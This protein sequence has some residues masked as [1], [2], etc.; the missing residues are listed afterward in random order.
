MDNI[1]SWIDLNVS[2]CMTLEFKI[3]FIYFLTLGLSGQ[4]GVVIPC[5]YL[6]V[7]LIL[8]PRQPKAVDNTGS[9]VIGYDAGVGV[10]KAPFVNFLVSKI[11]DLAKV[12]FRLFESHLYLTGVT[13]A[14]LRRHL[15][16]INVIF[17]S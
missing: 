7:N 1:F 10:T 6:P 4:T 13:A 11:F 5:I 3:M 14:E 15:P 16:N 2:S 17:N 8:S 9:E 12:P